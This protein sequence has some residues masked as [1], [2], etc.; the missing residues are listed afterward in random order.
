MSLPTTPLASAPLDPRL[1]AL[2][3]ALLLIGALMGAW[4]WS[5]TERHDP[6]RWRWLLWP[7]LGLVLAITVAAYAGALGGGRL[8]WLRTPG[9]D[10]ALHFLL[11][12]LVALCMHFATR[13]RTIGT[14]IGRASL[15]IPLA[16]GLPMVG[17]LAE[18]LA[19]AWS[20][21]RTADPLDLLA[22]LLGMVLFSWIGR[23]LTSGGLARATAGP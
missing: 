16:V 14:T 7:Q 8:P 6:W 18:E 5:R 10:K 2:A 19:Q 17:A 11:F 13:G 22:D 21:H 9:V 3:A 23:R 1:L 20:P 12:G 4:Q 15:R